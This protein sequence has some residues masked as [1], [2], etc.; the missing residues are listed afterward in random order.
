[1]QTVVAADFGLGWIRARDKRPAGIARDLLHALQTGAEGWRE[2]R[3]P[4]FA[5]APP[6]A[7]R[8]NR[9]AIVA[10]FRTAGGPMRYL[11]YDRRSDTVSY[12]VGT[13]LYEL[14]RALAGFGRYAVHRSGAAGG[15]PQETHDPIA[16]HRVRR[17]KAP[18]RR[19]QTPPPPPAP[20]T[21]P[22]RTEGRRLQRDTALVRT[23]LPKEQRGRPPKEAKKR[24]GKA[25]SAVV[26]R[27]RRSGLPASFRWPRAGWANGST[28]LRERLRPAPAGTEPPRTFWAGRLRVPY[29]WFPARRSEDPVG[30][31]RPALLLALGLSFLDLFTA[32]WVKDMLVLLAGGIAAGHR[33]PLPASV[34]AGAQMGLL[35][36]LAPDQVALACASAPLVAK[37]LA[38]PD[39][40]PLAVLG[41]SAAALAV[42]LSHDAAAP[43]DFSPEGGDEIVASQRHRTPRLRRDGGWT[44]PLEWLTEPPPAHLFVEVAGSRRR[45][46]PVC[47]WA[48]AGGRC[49][50]TV[51]VWL[52]LDHLRACW[53]G[54]FRRRFDLRATN[55]A[56]EGAANGAAKG[57]AN[58]ALDPGEARLLVG[59][60]WVPVGP[61]PQ[62]AEAVRWGE[63]VLARTFEFRAPSHFRGWVD[64]A[65]AW[66]ALTACAPSPDLSGVAAAHL[67]V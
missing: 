39:K 45:R 6:A 26:R 54:G 52:S 29:S 11:E 35:R 15:E 16:S 64:P 37:A 51:P 59:G 62:R 17:G 58:G 31:L 3:R 44:Q 4:D 27:K 57:A 56:A 43:P 66:F 55:G 38:P 8:V 61:E 67:F 41:A 24:R 50:V 34:H 7:L 33:H 48:S 28:W 19:A 1:M 49:S 5:A 60:R 12:A 21:M 9:S 23:R 20:L 30:G 18:R 22:L 46:L 14:P 2:G 10:L 63:A 47:A 13:Q 36:A 42:W 32:P 40:A 53:D 25:R 65:F